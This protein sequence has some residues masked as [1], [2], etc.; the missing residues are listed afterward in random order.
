MDA[1]GTL[2]LSENTF[3]AGTSWSTSSRG[4]TARSWTA[5]TSA[6][7]ARAAPPAAPPTGGRRTSTSAPPCCCRP[8]GEPACPPWAHVSHTYQLTFLLTSHVKMAPGLYDYLA[9]TV[10]CAG[11]M[12]PL[13]AQ[14][15]PTMN[16]WL[17]GMHALFRDACHDTVLAVPVPGGSLTAGTSSRRSG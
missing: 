7:C 1:R 10:S 5:C 11:I 12:I 8:T 15:A 17:L 4:R 2:T 3:T 16:L 13:H 14:C 9:E 6:F